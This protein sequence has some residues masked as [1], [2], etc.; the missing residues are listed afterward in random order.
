MND[1]RP[2][3]DSVTDSEN[4]EVI[5]NILQAETGGR[6]ST[7][8][9]AKIL[10]IVP[11]CWSLFQLWVASPLPFEFNFGVFNEDQ[12]K[13]I[14]LAFALFLA[15]TAFPMFKSNTGRIPVIDWVFALLGVASALYLLVFKD[16]LAGRS[17]A[18]ITFDLV[19]GVIG[20]VLLLEATRRS[21]G[22]PLMVVAIVFS[23]L[24]LLAALICRTLLPIKEQV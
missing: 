10:L 5:D 9:P 2:H 17:G 16:Q 14:H 23:C 19:I 12:T 22:L 18:P 15:F 1:E 24:H 7:G 21:L 8:I 11:L 4:R 20:M 3:A 6:A 13:Y